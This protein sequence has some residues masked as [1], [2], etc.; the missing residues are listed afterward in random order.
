[1]Y[2][3]DAEKWLSQLL[4]NTKLSA[5]NEDASPRSTGVSL[6]SQKGSCGEPRT[7]LGHLL[8][9][10]DSLSTNRFHCK[11]LA[12]TKNISEITATNLALQPAH[13]EVCA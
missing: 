2:V 5:L 3:L 9:P 4:C 10:K 13:F 6:R 7:R 1:M 12:T 8:Q 11:T